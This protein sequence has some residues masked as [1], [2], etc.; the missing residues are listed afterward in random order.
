MDSD[1]ADDIVQD[2]LPIHTEPPVDEFQPWHRV[3]KE[4]IRELQWN[5]LTRRMIKRYWRRQLS[6]SEEPWMLEDGP[7]GDVTIPEA[8]YLS[9]ALNCL[10]IPGEDLL[11]MR[12]LWRDIRPLN[13]KIRY[14]GFNESHSSDY[15]NTR[16]HV[17]HNTVTSLQDV[18]RES[19]VTHDRFE[20]VAQETS[21]AYRYMRH[22]GPFHIVNLDFCGSLFPNTRTENQ[23]FY[24]AILRL[25]TYQFDH[26]RSEWLLF[27]TTMVEPREHFPIRK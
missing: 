27:V 5:E 13:C 11:D 9:R 12:A 20:S 21:Q 10:V 25:L 4:Y 7:P 3:R 14:L 8:V 26:Q 15:R 22:Y 24:N 16:L 6:Q 2:E 1:F 19:Y 18:I 17:S 23:A